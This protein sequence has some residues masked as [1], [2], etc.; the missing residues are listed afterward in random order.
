MIRTFNKS[1]IG[2]Y[3]EKYKFST[4]SNRRIV[5]KQNDLRVY[6]GR[7]NS[8]NIR[9][10]GVEE[11]LS[12]LKK[13]LLFTE[14]RKN[15]KKFIIKIPKY[16]IHD[17]K[18]NVDIIEEIGRIHSFQKF[19]STTGKD[20]TKKGC[21]SS[22]LIKI[23]SLRKTLRDLGFNE[24]INCSLTSNLFN[25]GNQVNIYNPI[26]EE[27]INLRVNITEGLI[28]NYNHHVKYSAKN[29][30]I[31]EIGKVFQKN[32]ETKEYIET[33]QLAGLI[34]APKYIRSNWKEEPT[35][36]SLFHAKGL[37]E[38]L[39]EK[40]NSHVYM[41]EIS[42]HTS[43]YVIQ[44]SI[45]RNNVIGIYDKYNNRILG[46]L[47]ELSQKCAI[48]HYN[49]DRK[50]YLFELQINKFMYTMQKLEHLSYSKPIYSS[51][52]S[53]TRDICVEVD[54]KTYAKSIRKRIENIDKEIIE[55]IE[56][57]NE[58]KEF[59]TNEISG[60]RFIGIRITYR[61]LYKTL[62]T[63]DINKTNNT[64]YKILETKN[65]RKY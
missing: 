3:Y 4:E 22:N 43:D 26:S 44:D 27:Q 64:L 34:Y 1:V 39:I 25:T 30:L 14:Y 55:S 19:Y 10:L 6:L 60:T 23:N 56:I 46:I 42:E 9:F 53:I 45:K 48:K 2:N 35:N 58:Y 40:T 51:Y 65:K 8:S 28:K 54:E 36:I 7:K 61:S 62:N 12:I 52:P 24:V 5:I 32:K 15:S 31:F 50:I 16:R 49:K 47:G 37:I 29:L 17:L 57:F 59:S 18:R 33:K 11:T 63:K 41:K 20:Y 21:K 38:L 13:L